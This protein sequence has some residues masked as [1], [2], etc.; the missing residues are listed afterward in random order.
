MDKRRFPLL[1][2][3]L[4]PLGFGVMRL[5]MENGECTSEAHRLV[6]RAMEL[7]INYY[8][9]AYPYQGGK[10]EELIRRVL[11]DQFPRDSFYIADKLPVW[12]CSNQEDMERI[13]KTQLERLGTDHIDFYLLHGLHRSRWL[14]IRDKGVLD[15]L[16]RKKRDGAIHRIGFSLHDTPETLVAIL[17]AFDWEFVQLQINYYDWFVGGVAE[18]HR[19]LVE[20]NIPCLVMEPIGGGRLAKLP[21]AAEAVLESVRP[22]DSVASWAIRFVAALPNIAVTLSGMNDETQLLDNISRFDAI[23]P[24]SPTESA[25]L[26]KVVAILRGYNAI[27]CSGCRYCVKECPHGINIPDIIQRYNDSRMFEN[28]AK[29]NVDYFA[30][31][32]KDVRGDSCIACGKCSRQCPQEID[33]PTEL[34][35]IHNHAVG[36]ALALDPK[37]LPSILKKDETRPLVCFGAGHNGRQA[38]GILRDA[39][40][41]ADYFCDNNSALWGMEVDSTPVISPE[42]LRELALDPGVIVLITCGKSEEIREQ[43]RSMGVSGVVE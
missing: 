22:G 9:T 30:F 4:S 43:L 36:L 24:L 33:I 15:F 2:A 34:R 23:A 39:D 12:L 20:R 41:P 27:P 11:V 18:S 31:I 35:F 3:T 17:D 5:P 1:N 16:A 26:D 8:D 13:F 40:R 19:H 32:P 6:L 25:A 42:R 14:D 29:F 7:G 21:R 38:Q 10:S 28:A 37:K